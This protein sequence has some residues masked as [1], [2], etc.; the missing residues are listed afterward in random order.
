MR[1][2][3]SLVV[4]SA[5]L[6]GIVG[7][8]ASRLLTDASAQSQGA[9]VNADTLDGHHANQLSRATA[10]SAVDVQVPA[11]GTAIKAAGARMPTPKK[12]WVM[13]SA[14][15]IGAY[16]GDPWELTYAIVRADSCPAEP[17]TDAYSTFVYDGQTSFSTQQAF[18][19]GKGTHDFSLCAWKTEGTGGAQA[20][21]QVDL[22]L[23]YAAFDFDGR[24][25]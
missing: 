25:P 9:S 10:A 20:L 13:A 21:D 7:G 12:G 22:I 8:A 3:L 6:G 14:T 11:N 15:G 17:A 18:A 16:S 23:I 5:L 19:T 4:A 24:K 1:I 2:L